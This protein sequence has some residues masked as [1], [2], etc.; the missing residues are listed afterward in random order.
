MVTIHSLIMMWKLV[1]TKTP[2]ILSNA[3]HFE[4]DN[5]ISMENG[6]IL[7]SRRSFKWQTASSWNLLPTE[8]REI[9]TLPS[10]KKKLKTWVLSQRTPITVKTTYTNNT[11]LNAPSS[12]SSLSYQSPNSSFSS[13]HSQH[14]SSSSAQHHDTSPSPT[15]SNTPH[16]P[17]ISPNRGTT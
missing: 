17:P 3:F 7:L 15:H 5:T 1:R 14:S 9:P 8:I 13:T 6:R 16:N 11:S 10:F 12:N 4:H 2:K